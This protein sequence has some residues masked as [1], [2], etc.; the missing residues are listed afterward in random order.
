MSAI[1]PPFTTYLPDR[2]SCPLVLASPHSGH[3]Y[4]AD[5]VNDSRLTLTELRKSEDAFV[6]KL[7]SS[8]PELGIPLIAANFPRVYVDANR[9]AF[10][11]DP[12]MFKG[13]LP[14]YV[15]VTSPRITSGLGTIAKMAAGNREIYRHKLNFADIRKRIE[16]THIPYHKQL[17]EMVTETRRKFGRCL[18]IDCHSMPSGAETGGPSHQDLSDF[19]LGDR[20]GSTCSEH[21]I[22]GFETVLQDL[23]YSVGRNKPYAGGYTTRHYAHP[24]GGM[25]SL[26]IEINRRLYMDEQ[27]IRPHDGFGALKADLN[28]VLMTL[29]ET[30]TATVTKAAE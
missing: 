29:K 12:D 9:D 26:Q 17:F 25:E 13:S 24:S 22:S 2:Q 21:I 28:R 4:D 19:I 15:T 6:D 18:L 10:E 20:F 23:G 3:D 5:F 27:Q 8:A 14:D 7:F 1:S 16:N 11:L 30:L